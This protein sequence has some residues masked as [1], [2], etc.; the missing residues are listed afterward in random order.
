M[1]GR[2]LFQLYRTILASSEIKPLTQYCTN[3]QMHQASETLS[4]PN[5]ELIPFPPQLM[6][7]QPLAH[8]SE[9]FPRST[10]KTQL[11]NPAASPA[12]AT[13][14]TETQSQLL[15]TAINKSLE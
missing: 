1:S 10:Y 11:L 3:P 9:E 14:W 13:N 6:F 2:A 5:T 15:S 4:A 12:Q 8:T 7:L